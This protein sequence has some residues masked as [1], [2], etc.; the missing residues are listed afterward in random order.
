[1]LII[2]D[3]LFL[4]YGELAEAAKKSILRD[5]NKQ[6]EYS[7]DGNQQKHQLFV[8]DSNKFD[9]AIHI[10]IKSSNKKFVQ[11]V[12]KHFDLKNVARSDNVVD[13][14]AEELDLDRYNLKTVK[15]TNLVTELVEKC[16]NEPVWVTVPSK[17]ILM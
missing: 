15:W 1:M 14:S 17:P 2:F 3:F 13:A 11:H 9:N 5:A 16:Q 12:L 8:N 10:L 4:F 6:S 7:D